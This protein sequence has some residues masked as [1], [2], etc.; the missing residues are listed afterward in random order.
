MTTLKMY[1]NMTKGSKHLQKQHLASFTE[2]DH[3]LTTNNAVCW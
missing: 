2:P 1:E 3:N